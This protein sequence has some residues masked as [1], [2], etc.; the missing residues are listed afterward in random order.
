MLKLYFTKNNGG[1]IDPNLLPY[2]LPEFLKVTQHPIQIKNSYFD[3]EII[4][5]E[6]RYET[7]VTEI[8]ALGSGMTGNVWKGKWFNQLVA[9]KKAQLTALN[10]RL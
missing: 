4:E 7:E 6:A 2:L 10:S 3:V 1:E 5:N 9:I 8:V